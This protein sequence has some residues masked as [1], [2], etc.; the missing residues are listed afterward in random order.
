MEKSKLLKSDAHRNRRDQKLFGEWP[1]KML[2]GLIVTRL[3]ERGDRCRYFAFGVA[4]HNDPVLPAKHA[5]V[6]ITE[7]VVPC[8]HDQLA[9][10]QQT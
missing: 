8:L 3:V 9:R 1:G 4:R 2:H 10:H 6:V 7:L 5:G